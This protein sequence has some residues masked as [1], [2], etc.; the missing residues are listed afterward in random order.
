MWRSPVAKTL[1]L[2]GAL[3]LTAVAAHAWPARADHRSAVTAVKLHCRDPDAPTKLILWTT[4]ADA[5][6]GDK[7]VAFQQLV[8]LTELVDADEQRHG[9]WVITKAQPHAPRLLH[10][11]RS[12]LA[13]SGEARF[14]AGVAART[15]T[16]GRLSYFSVTACD[17]KTGPRTRD[18]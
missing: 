10:A 4:G 8:D 12:Q 17:R 1:L 16:G 15:E 18:E 13:Q 3:L 14:K 2:G 9:R 5:D 11:L 7:V 6:R